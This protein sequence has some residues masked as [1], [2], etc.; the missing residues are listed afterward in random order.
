MKEKIK[1]LV[2]EDEA[3]L[4]T[5]LDSFLTGRGYSV[6]T[7]R[8]GRSAL[9]ALRAESYDVALLDIVMPEMDGLE[10]LRQVR[11]E[12]TPPEV[13]IIT[14][15]GTIETAISA[16][17]LG[18]YDYM[19]K[20]YRMAEI[21]VLVR[22]AWEKRQ[23][24]KE[25]EF[26][27]SRLSRVDA[28]PEIITQHAAMQAVLTLV[29]R[30]ARSDAAVLVTGESGTGKELIAKAVHRLSPRADAPMVD[31]NCAAIAENL[32]ESELFGHEKGAFTGAMGRKTGLFEMAAGGTLFM[33][34]IGE[35]DPKLQGKLLRA[36]ET[37]TFF[38]VGGTQKVE[39]DVRIIAATNKDL[40][41][42]VQDGTFRQDLFYRIN[43]LNI[44]LPPL[45]DRA[46]DIPL[47][48]DHFLHRYGGANPPRLSDEAITALQAYSWPGNVRELR[49]VIERAVLLANGGVI[50][51]R[52][53]PLTTA[54]ATDVA[55]ATGS[56]LTLEELERRHIEAVLHQANWHQGKAA[57]V[58]GISS[59]TLYRKI[60]E[61]GF[62]RPKEA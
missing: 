62:I 47:I 28:V 13:I 61:Y 3:N 43:T 58:L 29:E 52:D 59:K 38:R 56:E 11:D 1:V 34:E 9:Q 16:M 6:T 4:G 40:A 36:L 48:A 22:R 21:D 14:G 57:T 27:H 31:I 45:R 53:L 2:A 18:A 39:V 26:L 5:I 32:M 12:P 8:D 24:S 23:L 49:N 42:A 30:L 46:L 10:V 7:C 55:R 51:S 41:K 15:N 17:K 33:D 37:G 25:N 20:P 54:P 50:Y 60:R 19:S 35:L 44:S